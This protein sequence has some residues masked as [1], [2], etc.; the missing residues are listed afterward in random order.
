MQLP[1]FQ[2]ITRGS[3]TWECVICNGYKMSK[4]KKSFDSN[5]IF[6]VVGMII[7]VIALLVSIIPLLW[8]VLGSFRTNAE[9]FSK[10]LGLPV[11]F[12]LSV[13]RT[14]WERA[15]FGMALKNSVLNCVGTDL[16]VLFASATAAFALA[17]IRFP[18]ARAI[19]NILSSSLVISGQLILIPLF[20]VL[21]D[22]KVYNTLWST[23]IADAAMDLPICI[24]LFITFF[25]EIPY[26]IEESTMIDGCSKWKF[27]T[28]FIV[29][30]SKPIV[31]TVIIFVSLWTWNEYLFA[32]TFL[33]DNLARTIPLQLQN[34]QGRW[35]TEYGLL[36]AAL[37]I[38]I[39]PLIILYISMQKSFIKGLTAGAV[40]M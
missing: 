13:F 29:P 38:S 30:L 3:I 21:K 12:D 18:G 34:F 35:A 26:E 19:Q 25:Q 16:I 23:I 24:T 33:K 9:M 37:S 5:I 1:L 4:E 39:V 8:M 31:S 11:S 40:K 10:P 36:F 2:P 20:F 14:A 27:F 17:R 28:G 7:L 15:D 22:I 32:L 6:N